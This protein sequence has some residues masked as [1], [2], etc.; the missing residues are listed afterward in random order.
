MT[1][2]YKKALE[3]LDRCP[4]GTHVSGGIDILILNDTIKKALT[5]MDKQPEKNGIIISEEE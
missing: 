3:A 4:Y 5:A 2:Q 1:D